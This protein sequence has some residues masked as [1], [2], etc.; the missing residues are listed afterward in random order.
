MRYKRKWEPPYLR[1]YIE[2]CCGVSYRN[3]SCGAIYATC[4][5]KGLKRTESVETSGIMRGGGE[6]GG[7]RSTPHL[8]T[9]IKHETLT[10]CWTSVVYDGP[11]ADQRW[12]THLVFSA[13]LSVARPRL[14]CLSLINH[15]PILEPPSIL[16]IPSENEILNRC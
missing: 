15:K 2:L 4:V 8:S 1:L 5:L 13:L 3:K 14:T 9:A 6:G 16:N 7:G 10:Q 11:T 12:A